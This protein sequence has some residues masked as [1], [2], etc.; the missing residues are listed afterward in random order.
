MKVKGLIDNISIKLISLKKKIIH[1]HLHTYT[2]P[3]TKLDNGNNNDHN[4]NTKDNNNTTKRHN[5]TIKGTRKNTE[6]NSIKTTLPTL[7]EAVTATTIKPSRRN[8]ITRSPPPPRRPPVHG[9]AAQC[10]TSTRA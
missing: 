3:P 7:A 10:I 8:N 9:E 2:T 1:Q 4:N 5:T 6:R